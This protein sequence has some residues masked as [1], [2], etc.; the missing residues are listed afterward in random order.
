MCVC[1]CLCVYAHVFVCMLVSNEFIFIP[2]LSF[3][4][5]L[6]VL[7]PRALLFESKQDKDII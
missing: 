3:S 5:K 7:F 4:L 1:M 6:F 2:D